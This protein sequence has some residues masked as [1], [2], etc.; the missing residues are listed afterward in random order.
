[1]NINQKNK[2]FEKAWGKW[3]FR[4]SKFAAQKKFLNIDVAS[5]ILI[6]RLRIYGTANIKLGIAVLFH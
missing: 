6:L 2:V 4:T 1:M 3:F 5:K